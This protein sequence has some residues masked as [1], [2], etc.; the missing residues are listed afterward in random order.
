MVPDAYWHEH[1]DEVFYIVEG[2]LEM[3]CGDQVF[4]VEAG[5][6]IFYRSESRTALSSDPRVCAL[7]A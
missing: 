4:Q 6:C 1:E 2:H 5:E 3:H 7:S